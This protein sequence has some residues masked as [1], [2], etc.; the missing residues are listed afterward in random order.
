MYQHDEIIQKAHVVCHK[1]ADDGSFPNNPVLPI[2]VYKGALLLHP[3]QDAPA[4]K[5][6]FEEHGWSNSWEAGIYDYH[7]YHSVTHE[8]LGVI[9]GKAEVQLGGPEGVC[10]ELVRGDVVV[11][12]AG[13]A[14][15]CL[16]SSKDFRVVG[17]YPEGRNYDMNYGREGER[18][19]VD[20]NIRNVSVPDTDPVYG[21]EGPLIKNWKEGE[22]C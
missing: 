6:I 20:D 17:A 9:C 8:V 3:E 14:H 10:V 12:P 2:M 15:K 13:V 16:S 18:P 4:V 19:R 22:G 5:K 1:C 7:H 11:I 21:S